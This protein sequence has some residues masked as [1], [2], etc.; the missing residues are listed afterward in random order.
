M[1]ELGKPM[2][3][4]VKLLS[5]KFIISPVVKFYSKMID[6]ICPFLELKLDRNE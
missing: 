5:H 4:V 2:N 1:R 3:I 6:V